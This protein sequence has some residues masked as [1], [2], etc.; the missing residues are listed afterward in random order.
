MEQTFLG[1]N[2]ILSRFMDQKPENLL[3]S[4]Q[5]TLTSLLLCSFIQI[6]ALYHEY[7]QFK[8]QIKI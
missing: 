2:I 5:Y 8:F 4:V 7:I 1:K 3:W 6:I